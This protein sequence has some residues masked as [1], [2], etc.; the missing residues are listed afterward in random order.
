MAL[1]EA[2]TRV[3]EMAEVSCSDSHL[4]GAPTCWARVLATHRVR[5]QICWAKWA[6]VPE[7]FLTAREDW[8]LVEARR[9]VQTQNES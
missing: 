7:L 8:L 6:H 5:E 9:G 1:H 4:C 3:S 2:V